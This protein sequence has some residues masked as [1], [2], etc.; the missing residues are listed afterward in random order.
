MG[1]KTT[2][3]LGILIFA[4]GIPYVH[5]QF[6]QGILHGTQSGGSGIPHGQAVQGV[7]PYS[8]SGSV[9]GSSPHATGGSGPAPSAPGY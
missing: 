9:G 6:R 4:L 5:R 1:L 2:I 8:V 3:V 7:K